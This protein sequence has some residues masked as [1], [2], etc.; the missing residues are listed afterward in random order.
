M[1]MVGHVVARRHEEA[2]R[3]LR[4]EDVL[5]PWD[6]VLEEPVQ[7]DHVHA[8][9]FVEARHPRADRDAVM[10]DDL[11]PQRDHLLAGDAVADGRGREF[12]E[13]AIERG[14][15]VREPSPDV[16]ADR[17]PAVGLPGCNHE[18]RVS[19]ELVHLERE[20]DLPDHGGQQV[21]HD[22][23]RVNPR[24]AV[25]EH[26]PRVAAD[27][28]DQEEKLVVNEGFRGHAESLPAR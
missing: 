15:E 5:R 4:Q 25:R 22:A 9:E 7:Y 18:D 6:D 1:L 28:G 12:R 27:V 20:P 14:D 2:E 13:L 24:R 17:L 21:G 8:G 3:G 23:V 11:Q 16:G 10:T 26:E 19:L